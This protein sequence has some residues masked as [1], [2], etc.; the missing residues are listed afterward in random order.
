MTLWYPHSRKQENI[1]GKKI[2]TN[3]PIVILDN[4]SFHSEESMLKWKN[5]YHRKIALERELSKEAL[6]F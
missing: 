4:V 2:P 5:A 3:V 1:G 6:T